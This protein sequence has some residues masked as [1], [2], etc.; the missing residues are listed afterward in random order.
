M[1]IM[2]PR[3]GIALVG[4]ALLATGVTSMAVAAQNQA[5]AGPCYSTCPPKMKLD[6]TPNVVNI[7]SEEVADFSVV[8]GADFID[9]GLIP[10]GTVTVKSGSTALCTIVLNE[11]GRGS[12]SP[13]A[14]ALPGGQ[15]Y[16]IEAYY[17]GDDN[18]SPSHS[19]VLELEVTNFPSSD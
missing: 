6:I 15:T 8:V 5:P 17:N 2:Q 3:T 4:A 7:G 12:C 19:E 14:S 10:T 18:F 13:S 9:S 11:K 16:P 1:R